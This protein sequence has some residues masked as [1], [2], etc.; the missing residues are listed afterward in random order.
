MTVL[1][2]Y[3]L[4]D[5]D[6]EPMLAIHGITAHGRRFRRLAEE[7][8]PERRTVAVDLR[9]HGHSTSDGPWSIPQH[10]TDLLDTLDDL[11]LDGVDVVGHSDGG[12]IA[13]ALLAAAPE[14]VRRWCCSTRRSP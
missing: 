7:A 10:V 9:G 3:E 8:W 5:P 6:G 2:T 13:L 1:H 14:R 11:G 12:A 4:G